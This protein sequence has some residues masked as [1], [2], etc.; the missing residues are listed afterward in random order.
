M[1]EGMGPRICEDNGGER[2]GMDSRSPS[3]R[4]QALREK[5]EGAAGVMEGGRDEATRFLDSASLRSNDMWVT[6]EGWVPAVAG[7]A[8]VGACLEAFYL[9]HEG[10]NHL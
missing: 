3:S 9:G 4:G 1:E 8:G 5:T 7:I 6:E 2:R 10:G